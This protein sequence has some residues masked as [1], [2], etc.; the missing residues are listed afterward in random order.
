MLAIVDYGLGN[1]RSLSNAIEAVGAVPELVSDPD[2]LHNADRIILP[3][4]GAAAEAL[5][6]LRACGLN[7]AIKEAAG[8]GV[9]LLG[10]CL[11]MQLLCTRSFEEGEHEALNLID[12]D[13]VRFDDGSGLKVPH[14]GWNSITPAKD[15]ALLADVPAG[16]DVYFVH[17]YYVSCRDQRDV[18]ASTDYGVEFASMIARDNVL[19][20]QFH[21]EKSQFPGLKILANFLRM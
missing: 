12:A 2:T 4:V 17:S 18:L 21:P 13:V 3:G 20:A 11:G 9:P 6:C 14:I 16:S 5:A 1:L 7:E 15:H 19:G 10:V 8:R